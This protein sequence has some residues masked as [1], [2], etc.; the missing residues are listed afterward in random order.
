[1]N[2]NL[3]TVGLVAGLALMALLVSACGDDDSTATA[4][5]SPAVTTADPGAVY[6]GKA[7]AAA[8]KLA[9]Q[10]E[11][12]LQDMQAAQLSQADPKWPATLTA[13][14]DLITAA[15]TELKGLKPPAGPLEDVARRLAE[16]ADRLTEGAKFLKQSVQ[17]ADPVA[18]GQAFDALSDGQGKLAA[19]AP[20][21]AQ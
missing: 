10:A 20:S 15:A 13:D 8:A 17:N 9:T 2:K 7:Q 21:L 12:A 11:T 16:A 6:R 3:C 14:A 19:A 1:V 4:T 5:P 18:G